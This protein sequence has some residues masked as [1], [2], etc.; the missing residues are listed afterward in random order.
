[1]VLE[2]IESEMSKQREAESKFM[3]VHKYVGPE[4]GKKYNKTCPPSRETGHVV[5][6]PQPKRSGGLAD[7]IAKKV[8]IG[9]ATYERSKKIIAKGSEDQKNSSRKGNVGIRKVYGQL[10]RDEKREEL[11]EKAGIE[12]TKVIKSSTSAPED[13][14]V[15][16]YHND[17]LRLTDNQIQ[18]ESIDLIFTDLHMTRIH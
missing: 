7:I 12:R 15:Q 10:R 16:L 3:P 9:R 17:F 18:P 8:G 5:D 1:V 2:E 6:T 11:I 13:N 14:T 4:K